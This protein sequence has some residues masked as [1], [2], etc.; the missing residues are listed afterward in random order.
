MIAINDANAQAQAIAE[1]LAYPNPDLMDIGMKLNALEYQLQTLIHLAPYVYP[2]PFD[3]QWRIA[4]MKQQIVDLTYQFDRL[5]G[6][7]AAVTQ[8]QV[9]TSDGTW[10]WVSLGTNPDLNPGGPTFTGTTP[11][12][13]G[14]GCA[15]GQTFIIGVGC[16]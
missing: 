11:P 2:D 6:W 3:L 10:S 7:G 13:G 5:G 8:H 1:E 9:L 4:T 15:P 12:R 16:V 14:S